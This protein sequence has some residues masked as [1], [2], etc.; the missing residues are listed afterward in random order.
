MFK[1]QWERALQIDLEFVF[2]TDWNQWIAVRLSEFASI[3][4]ALLCL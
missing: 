1:E 4:L 3:K 2:V